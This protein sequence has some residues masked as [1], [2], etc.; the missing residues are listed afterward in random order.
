MTRILPGIGFFFL[1]KITSSGSPG[2]MHGERIMSMV[3]DSRG[4][5][6]WFVGA[7]M[8][9]ATTLLL[10]WLGA[11][12]TAAGMVFLV[13]VVWSSTQA[14][15]LLSLYIAV[16]CALSFDYFFLLPYHTL[17]IAGP[18]EWVAMVSFVA[19]C[20]V[21]ERVAEMARR[22]TRQAE[23]RREDVERLY[24]LSQEM[25]LHEDAEG[26]TRDLPRMIDRIF[27]L[28]GVVLYVSD[29]NQFY[30]STSELPMSI[31]ASL[32]AMTQGPNPTLDLPGGFTAI[33]L[34]LGLRAVGAL[35]WRPGRLSREVATAVSAQVDGNRSL[36]TDGGCPRGRTAAHGAD[37]LADARTAHA[38]YVNP[39]RRHHAAPVG[40]V[41][42][43]Q[44]PGSGRNRGRR[45]RAAGRADRRGRR[46]GRD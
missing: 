22:Q 24:A 44:P 39:R 16:L 37:R 36:G 40:G 11:N 19:S 14:G 45:E 31:Q 15:L 7:L 4:V 25:M 17:R 2:M 20:V 1:R 23:Q 13:L 46:N 32:R 41:G 28:D 10:V 43:S 6:H 9:M 18:Q 29:E 42:R 33:S 3:S 26:L 38:A 5:V 30:A 8:A 27:A 21:V 12:S 34:M 35:G